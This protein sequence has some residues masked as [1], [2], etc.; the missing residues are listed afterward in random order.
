MSILILFLIL[1]YFL[2]NNKIMCQSNSTINSTTNTTTTTMIQTEQPFIELYT[3]PFIVVIGT[4]CNIL[5]FLVMR[6]KKMRHQSTYFY[7]AVLA[8]ADELVLLNGCLNVWIYIFFGESLMFTPFGCKIMVCVLL[9]EL[10]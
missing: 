2:P 7:M 10:N 4:V 8:I 3:F 1:L 9:N 6:R 5:T